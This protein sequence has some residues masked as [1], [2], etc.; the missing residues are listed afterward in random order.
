MGSRDG[1]AENDEQPV[2]TVSV[3]AFYMDKYEVTNAQYQAFIEA[4]PQWQK[5]RIPKKYHDG[6]YLK[7][8]TGNDYPPDIGDH[9]VV[10][11]SWYAAMAYAQWQGKRL[12][13]E[14]EWEWAARG[15][16]DPYGYGAKIKL[17]RRAQPYERD[18]FWDNSLD[19]SKANYDG[20]VGST[21]DVGTYSMNGYGL[22]DMTQ[23]MSGNGVL[24]NTMPTF[25]LLLRVKILLPV[26]LWL[27][28]Y[29]I[30]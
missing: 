26:E 17:Y 6:D 14:A 12:P 9:P 2:H 27:I 28:L 5:E 23:A 22:Y 25:I 30:L 7:H 8:W 18:N 4:N 21:T 13:T 24:M 10:Y 1:D 29:P 19:V 3:D 20:H 15:A 16:A 11:V